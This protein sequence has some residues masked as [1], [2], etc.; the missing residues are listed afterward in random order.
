MTTITV[1]K[2]FP[3]AEGAK[4]GGLKATDGKIYKFLP[5]Q[6]KFISEG[7]TLD[8]PITES[9]FQ[10]KSYFWFAKNWP[11]KDQ[12]NATHNQSH[13]VPELRPAPHP[14]ASCNK[15][16][17]ITATAL[18]KSFIETGNFGLTDLETLMKACVPA[19]RLMV[20]AASGVPSGDH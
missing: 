17:L 4:S 3:I 16:I 5:W 11:T 18:M 7:A 1:E 14:S 13:P 20:K 12:Q 15:D 6:A 2:V 10:G 19:A 8:V 9:E